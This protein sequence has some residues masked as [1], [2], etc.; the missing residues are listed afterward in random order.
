MARTTRST[1]NFKR[2]PPETPLDRTSPPIG[3]EVRGSYSS[4][5]PPASIKH[6][7]V[8]DGRSAHAG[9]CCHVRRRPRALLS[10]LLSKMTA[11]KGTDGKG[12]SLNLEKAEATCREADGLL[13]PYR[14]S[15][16]HTLTSMIVN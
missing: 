2:T 9:M 16:A 10:R 5:R 6:C 14:W 3:F 7:S 12:T 13:P 11:P 1:T 8:F 4:G 15:D